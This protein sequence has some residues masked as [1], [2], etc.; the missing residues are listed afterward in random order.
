MDSP[1]QPDH[2]CDACKQKIIISLSMR[3]KKGFLHTDNIFYE[4]MS[5][6]CGDLIFYN[7]KVPN[8]VFYEKIDIIRDLKRETSETLKLLKQETSETIKELGVAIHG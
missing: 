6:G 7:N 1:D 8:F 3:E 5:C 4:K 2:F